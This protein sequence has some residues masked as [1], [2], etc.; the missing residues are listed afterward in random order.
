MADY[1]IISPIPGQTVF[2]AVNM[3]GPGAG[4]PIHE[5]CV[6]ME[7][8]ATGEDIARTRHAHPA[9]PEAA[10]ETALAATARYT[11]ADAVAV[12]GFLEMTV[13]TML[14]YS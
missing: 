10:R 1:D 11:H 8:R 4:E 2:W 14:N 13:E 6:G 7:F 12:P 9:F 5:I 3:I